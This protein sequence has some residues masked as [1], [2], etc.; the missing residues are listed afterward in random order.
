MTKKEMEE[1]FQC[2]QCDKIYAKKYSL[3]MHVK[4][5]SFWR[6]EYFVLDLHSIRGIFILNKCF[7]LDS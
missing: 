3:L 5:V 4:K 7:D 6:F 2:D 1:R